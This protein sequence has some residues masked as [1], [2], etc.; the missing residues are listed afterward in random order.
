MGDKK[1]SPILSK[2]MELLRLV[3]TAENG[4]TFTELQDLSGQP[5]ATLHRLIKSLV[6]ERLLA[7]E[8]KGH[9]YVLG[10]AIFELAGQSVV[11][12]APTALS[13]EIIAALQELS[14]E[15]GELVHI[16]V[17][18]GSIAARIRRFD[19]NVELS[20][21]PP[22]EHPAACT[23]G[24]KILLAQLSGDE[25]T[26]TIDSLTF[27]SRGPNTPTTR[28]Q[29]LADL[30]QAEKNAFAIEDEE[31]EAGRKSIACAIYDSTDRAVCS[32]EMSI[33]SA[34][35]DQARMRRLIR[36]MMATAD[37]ISVLQGATV[38]KFSRAPFAPPSAELSPTA[39]MPEGDV[40]C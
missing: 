3:G 22:A 13:P 19:G 4:A 36:M 32:V 33:T 38:R 11:A 14:R 27:E 37:H 26:K 9:R 17:L 7:R 28:G 34:S 25:L 24:G 16:V 2:S 10:P 5:K 21:D 23:A 30:R 40:P 39:W 35:F 29:F 1:G 8:R 15:S 12:G 20:L 31:V 6:A 18:H